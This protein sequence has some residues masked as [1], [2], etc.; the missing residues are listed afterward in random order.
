MLKNVW[1]KIHTLTSAEGKKKEKSS[2]MC[3]VCVCV[4]THTHTHTHT[5]I[6]IYIYIYMYILD[7]VYE[8]KYLLLE[9]CFMYTFEALFEV[10]LRIS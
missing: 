10:L 4:Y 3:V 5:H 9:K 1:N 2:K 7:H 8:E 6:Y